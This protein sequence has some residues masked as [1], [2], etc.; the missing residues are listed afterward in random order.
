MYHLTGCS[1]LRSPVFTRLRFNVETLPGPGHDGEY[2]GQLVLA[3]V[4]GRRVLFADRPS[5]LYNGPY[6]NYG[7]GLPTGL[8]SRSDFYVSI[9]THFMVV[10]SHLLHT[11]PSKVQQPPPLSS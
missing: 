5:A 11:V 9:N 8:V 1:A 4:A 3:G 7:G 6:V 2:L 10:D